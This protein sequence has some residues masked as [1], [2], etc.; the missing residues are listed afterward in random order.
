MKNK[1]GMTL[2]EVLVASVIV[3]IIAVGML[4]VFVV[5]KKTTYK[6]GDK[7]VAL[8]DARTKILK[9]VTGKEY[10]FA[11]HWEAVKDY[12]GLVDATGSYGSLPGEGWQI[13]ELDASGTEVDWTDDKKGICVTKAAGEVGAYIEYC[14]KPIKFTVNWTE[15]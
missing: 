8:N 2:V 9:E 13:D 1:S 3:G 5:A 14:Y 15:R 12:E 11:E 6:A 7:I 4:G 10:N